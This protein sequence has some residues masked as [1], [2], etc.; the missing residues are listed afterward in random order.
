[1][2]TIDLLK[3]QGLPIKSRPEGIVVAAVTLAVPVVIAIAMFSFY[4]RNSIIISIKKQDIVNYEAK[5]SK[6]SDAVEL[7]KS[8]EKEKIAYGGCLSEVR[9]SINRHTQWSPILAILVQ[10]IPDSVVLEKLG[11]GQSTVK[12]QVP[13]KDNPQEMVYTNITVRTLRMSIYGSPYSNCGEAVR[14][15]RNRLWSSSLLGPKLENIR[16]SQKSARVENRDVIS[17]EIECVFKPEM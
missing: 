12:K 3:G 4:L 5:L 7:Q 9:D 13:R 16:V 15:F 1:M 17:Y 14:E 8:F 11:V 6:L 2:F 10:N